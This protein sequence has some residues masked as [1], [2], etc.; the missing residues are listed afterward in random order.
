[1]GPAGN[2]SR[3]ALCAAAGGFGGNT[4]GQAHRHLLHHGQPGPLLVHARREHP[5]RRHPAARQ[6]ARYPRRAPGGHQGQPVA[7]LHDQQP[8]R[9]RVGEP[10][11]RCD[12]DDRD[13]QG[14]N[15]H[16]ADVVP[17]RHPDRLHRKFRRRITRV[18]R[19]RGLG[20]VHAGEPHAVDAH[21]VYGSRVHRRRQ[22][23]DRRTAARRSRCRADAR[24]QRHRGRPDGSPHR[25]PCRS[26]A[27]ARQLVARSSRQGTAQALLDGPV[28]TDR[29]E[30]P[31][32]E[33]DRH[34][35]NDP[36][37]VGFT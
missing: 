22:E 7:C 10:A 23:P 35:Q 14:R 29:R 1:M 11:H 6:G 2:P 18:C 8:D 3:R 17:Q 12:Q 24:P 19:G 36:R 37:R 20:Q 31:C 34:A 21:D 25:F 16:G 13:A 32:R 26:A 9:P 27:G 15:D 33:K 30:V 28:G 4:A 5:A